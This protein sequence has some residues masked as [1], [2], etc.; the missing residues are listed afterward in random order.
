M[1]RPLNGPRGSL[2]AV[3]GTAAAALLAALGLEHLGGYEPCNLCI[4]ERYPCGVVIV[5]GLAGF[6]SGHIRVALAAVA[7]SLLANVG[8]SAYHVGV[9]QGWLVL[10]EG[11]SAGGS[12]ASVEDLRSQLAAAPARCDQAVL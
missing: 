2:A 12:A 9:E 1:E 5:D 7:L 4:Q 6:W 3:A 8:L 11:C 10:P